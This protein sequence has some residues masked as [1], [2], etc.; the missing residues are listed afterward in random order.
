M[1]LNSQV[2]GQETKPTKQ[3][4]EILDDLGGKVDVQLQRL[5]QLEATE[6]KAL[7]TLLQEIGLPPIFV[8]PPVVKKAIS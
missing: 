3:H 6:I 1:S 2:L 4:G 5:Q 8:P 7:N